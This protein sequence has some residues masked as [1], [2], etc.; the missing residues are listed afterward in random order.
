MSEGLRYRSQ[1]HRHRCCLSVAIREILTYALLQLGLG[2]LWVELNP[3]HVLAKIFK[4]S[5]Q[6]LSPEAY[7]DCRVVFQIVYVEP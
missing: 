6:L 5:F 3:N 7:R 4:A 1:G 2:I